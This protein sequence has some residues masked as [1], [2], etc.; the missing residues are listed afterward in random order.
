[1]TATA[2][3]HIQLDDAGVAWINGTNTKVIE[4]VTM[5]LAY[6]WDADRLQRA[7][8]HVTLA[9]VHSALAYYY[10]HKPQTDADIDRRLQRADELATRHENPALRRKL[11]AARR[12][13]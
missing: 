12:S 10:D 1:M 3:Q 8:P 2:Y 9:Q 11:E 7:L 6:D 4:L 5:S 13:A